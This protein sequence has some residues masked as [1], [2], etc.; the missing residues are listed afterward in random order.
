MER[1]SSI[2][3]RAVDVGLE[4]HRQRSSALDGHGTDLLIG[5]D[6]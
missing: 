6:R 2:T 3:N 1:Y 4:V 5:Q